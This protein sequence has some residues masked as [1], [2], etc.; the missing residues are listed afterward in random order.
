MRFRT[1]HPAPALEKTGAG[2]SLL[3]SSCPSPLIQA[4]KEGSEIAQSFT[5][6][7][8][9][10]LTPKQWN[11]MLKTHRQESK[12]RGLHKQ[13]ST[14]RELNHVNQQTTEPSCFCM[15]AH[16]HQTKTSTGL[17]VCVKGF[18]HGKHALNMHICFSRVDLSWVAGTS[19]MNLVK[20]KK[21]SSALCMLYLPSSV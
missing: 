20:S 10:R 2:R 15:A 6:R 14:L 16:F 4:I 7:P 18:Q 3:P 11:G 5:R 21:L 9:L 19:A 1:H 17:P 12:P 8:P 13:L